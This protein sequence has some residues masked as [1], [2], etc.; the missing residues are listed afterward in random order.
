MTEKR[1]K[2]EKEIFDGYCIVDSNIDGYYAYEKNDLE[3]FCDSLN[4]LNNENEQLKKENN[5]NTESFQILYEQYKD[6]LKIIKN[7]K[8]EN[9]QL[10]ERLKMN[11]PE[12]VWRDLE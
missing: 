4:E 5:L 7:L 11:C 8:K 3:K 2:V 9:K 6:A 12:I 10:K 1:F